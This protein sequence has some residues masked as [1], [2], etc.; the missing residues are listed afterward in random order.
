VNDRLSFDLFSFSFTFLF[1]F[2]LL[3]ILNLDEECNVMSHVT[4]TEVTKHNGTMIPITA[5]CYTII[6]HREGYKRF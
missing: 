4:V 6:L 5:T 3:F 1:L 2:L